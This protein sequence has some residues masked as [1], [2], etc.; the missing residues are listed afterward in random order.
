M[1]EGEHGFGPQFE[2]HYEDYVSEME[3]VRTL[4]EAY[5]NGNPA[6]KGALASAREAAEAKATLAFK[7]VAANI[8]VDPNVM[9]SIDWSQDLTADAQPNINTSGE[10]AE[11]GRITD[12]LKAKFRDGGVSVAKKLSEVMGKDITDKTVLFET[13][14]DPST[15]RQR[16][17][18]DPENQQKA[19]NALENF[20]KIFGSK[21]AMVFYLLCVMAGGTVGFWELWK[22]TIG[23]DIAKG[24]SG[25]FA[26]DPANSKLQVVNY[27]SKVPSECYRYTEV[28]GGCDKGYVQPGK[29]AL[30]CTAAVDADAKQRKGWTYTLRCV[31]PAQGMLESLNAIGD[32]LNPGNL[33]KKLL[34]ILLY[35]AI[36]VIGVVVIF[37]LIRFAWSKFKGNRHKESGKE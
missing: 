32:V 21:I 8:G 16:V 9:G 18:D 2:G 31:S 27:H 19:S 13:E 28:C 30:C 10:I 34:M 26:I 25:C 20:K 7:D 4:Q 15:G 33:L 12:K 35:V 6:V 22:N 36:A 14:I 24:Q 1:A 11:L 5:N 23:C 37:Y 17:K 29:A 3:Q